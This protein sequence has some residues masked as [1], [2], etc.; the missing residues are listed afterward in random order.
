MSVWLDIIGSFVIGSLLAL[1]V[2]RMN[3]DIA[4]V[5]YKN[6]LAYTAHINAVTA[7]EILDED[8]QKMGYGVTST[9]ITLAD[10][11]QIRFLGDLD[12]DGTVDTLFYYIGDVTEASST[13][14][15]DD[16]ILYRVLNSTTPQAY[17]MGITEFYLSYFGAAGDS[18]G[19]PPT[20]GDIRQVRVNLWVESTVPYDTTYAQAFM[21]LRVVPKN[22]D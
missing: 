20:L 14:N 2:M 18:L 6:S 11:L 16:R 10:S 3:A 4:A 8:F 13:T 9:A 7:A 5:S 21:Q 12:A 17:P 15:P 19:L 22:L 1:N